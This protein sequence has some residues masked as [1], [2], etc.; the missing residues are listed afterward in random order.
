MRAP[1][2]LT[3]AV[4]KI[5]QVTPN[6]VRQLEAR[7]DLHADRTENG[8]RLFDRALVERVA[9]ERAKRHQ[10]PRTPGDETP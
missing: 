7:G 6:Y 1:K 10:H 2:L 8:T 9:V 5:L 3:A 4:A